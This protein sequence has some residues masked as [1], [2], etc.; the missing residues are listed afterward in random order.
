M[1]KFPSRSLFLK[2][3]MWVVLAVALVGPTPGQVGGCT[4]DT[5]AADP[6][7]FC[8]EKNTWICQRDFAAGRTSMVERDTCLFNIQGMC[9]GAAWSSCMPPTESQAQVCIDALADPA[10]LAETSD[11]IAECQAS[12]LCPPFES[13]V[14]PEEEE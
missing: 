5:I 9:A 2:L 14:G 7:E 12:F 11:R 6:V 3:A 8:A 1:K 10:R 13:L 4:E